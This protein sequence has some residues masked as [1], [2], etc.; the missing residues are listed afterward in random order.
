MALTIIHM[1]LHFL[2]TFMLAKTA[3]KGNW[4]HPFISHGTDDCS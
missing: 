4:L 1:N 2:V 3:C